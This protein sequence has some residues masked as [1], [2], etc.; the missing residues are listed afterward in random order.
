[1]TA[2]LLGLRSTARTHTSRSKGKGVR[3][4]AARRAGIDPVYERAYLLHAQ[5]AI[6]GKT[7][8]GRIGVPGRHAPIHENL[9]HHGG[10]SLDHVVALHCP[11]TDA[12]GLVASHAFF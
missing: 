3:P 7:A 2:W 4:L 10:P 11:G 12:P 5:G 1:M 9:P 8:D 6:V